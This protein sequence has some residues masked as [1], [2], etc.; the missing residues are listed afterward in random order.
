MTCTHILGDPEH[1]CGRPAVAVW[2]HP[3]TGLVWLCADHDRKALRACQLD[4]DLFLVW[5]RLP[6][7]PQSVREGRSGSTGPVAA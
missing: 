4:S 7:A 6:I 1:P 2:E 5:D 3:V